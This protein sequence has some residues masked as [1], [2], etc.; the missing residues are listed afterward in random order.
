MRVVSRG[1]PTSGF[2]AVLVAV[3]VA[4]FTAH[5]ATFT[6]NTTA[7]TVAVAPTTSPKDSAGNVSLRSAIMAANAQP[8]ADTIELQLG[9]TYQLSIA[10]PASDVDL[11]NDAHGDLDIRGPLTIN[12]HSSTVDAMG[13]DRVFAIES[14]DDVNFVVT[15]NDLTIKGG[16]PKGF[17]RAGGGISVRAAT[18]NMMNC[19]VK[20]NSTLSNTGPSNGGGIAANGVGVPVAAPAT[21]NLTACTVS[22]NS[23]NNGGGIVA[24]N[25]AVTLDAVT[26]S[27]NNAAGLDPGT[28]GGGIFLAGSNS[29]GTIRNACLII[30]NTGAAD[31]G[32]ISVLSSTLTVTNS[33]ISGNT[34]GQN[35]GGVYNS[36]ISPGT[37]TFAGSTISGN[38]ANPAATGKGAGGGIYSAGPCALTNCTISGNKAYSG[39]GIAGTST[40]SFT[41]IAANSAT[42]GGGLYAS[43]GTLSL[44]GCILGDNSAATGPDGYGPV[45]SQ[46]YNIVGNTTSL[47]LGGVLTGNLL[48]VNPQIGPLAYNGGAKFT[49][50]LLPTSPAIDAG[51]LSGFPA[52]DQRGFARPQD[53]RQTGTPR[54][55]VGAYEYIPPYS[56][57]EAGRALRIAG[58][59]QSATPFDLIR[60][61]IVGPGGYVS[62]TDATRIIRKVLG[63][64]SNP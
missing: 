1:Y 3:A 44:L 5:S 23:A 37:L 32:G 42:Q 21:L 18:L 57:S 58:G 2:V 40:A 50:A 52:T 30:G 53:G 27:G 54:C 11:R 19:V 51:P 12:G 36:T 28:G 48:G 29:T 24:A 64:E 14:I 39:G 6:V 8:G 15:I 55:D 9:M 4:R 47:S 33:T 13:I 63:I 22:G 38:T 62:V 20:D 16:K 31:G 56:A 41:T 17:E 26:V 43:G 45:L 7:D 35:G 49:H 34:S 60:L 10:P 61:D 46:G 59:L 25:C